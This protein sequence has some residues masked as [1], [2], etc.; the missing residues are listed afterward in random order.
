MANPRGYQGRRNE[1]ARIRQEARF[2][3]TPIADDLN[4]ADVMM[5]G[6]KISYTVCKYLEEKIGE[7]GD[8]GYDPETGLVQLQED[9]AGAA[10]AQTRVTKDQELWLKAYREE[11]KLMMANAK[12]CVEMGMSE[13]QL[14][15]AEQQAEL[16]FTVVTQ[17]VDALGLTTEQQRMVPKLLPTIIRGIAIESS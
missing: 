11:R 6:L 2:L 3:G 13:R 7:W 4:P 10:G 8:F 5:Y 12:M 9:I 14:Q 1:V 16:M 17:M 15:L